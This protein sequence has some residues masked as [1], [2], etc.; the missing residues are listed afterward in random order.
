MPNWEVISGEWTLVQRSPIKLCLLVSTFATRENSPSSDLLPLTINT[1][2]STIHRQALK[3]KRARKLFPLTFFKSTSVV[4]YRPTETSMKALSPITF[5]SIVMEWATQW[6]N[7]SSNTSLISS[8]RS[9]LTSMTLNL[10]DKH[11]PKSHSSSSI[12][13]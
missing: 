2:A 12:S 7:R 10:K 1:C 9:S 3:D 8:R 4:H 6:E 13:A 11:F 5:S